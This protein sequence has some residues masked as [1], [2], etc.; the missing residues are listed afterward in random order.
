MSTYASMY[1]GHSFVDTASSAVVVLRI[2]W[3]ACS[4]T[5]G[6]KLHDH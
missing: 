3:S 4:G 2:L 5:V 6:T 1:D